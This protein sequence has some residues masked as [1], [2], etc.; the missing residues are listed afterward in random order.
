MIALKLVWLS[1][2]P[3]AASETST[4]HY[5]RAFGYGLSTVLDAYRDLILQLEQKVT[6]DSLA[7]PTHG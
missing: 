3:R 7:T 2:V 1:L 4:G 6:M 5:L